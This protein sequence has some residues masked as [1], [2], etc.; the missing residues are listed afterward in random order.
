MFVCTSLHSA[1]CLFAG[2][3]QYMRRRPDLVA[4]SHHAFSRPER[5]CSS[6]ASCSRRCTEGHA[7]LPCRRCPV[8]SDYSPVHD[9]K[10]ASRT[11]VNRPFQQRLDDT[12][13]KLSKSSTPPNRFGNIRP[14]LNGLMASNLPRWGAMTGIMAGASSVPDDAGQSV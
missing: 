6:A 2:Q 11:M 9:S 8:P 7:G 4:A 10:P 13:A 12:V 1:A 3:G 5:G 14:D